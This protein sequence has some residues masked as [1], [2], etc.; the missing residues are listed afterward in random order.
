MEEA[1]F[2]KVERRGLIVYLYYNRDVKKLKKYGDILYHSRKH[3][4]V[5]IYVNQDQVEELE[6]KLKEESFV[7]E[8]K[9]TLLQDLDQNFVGS[10]WREK[11][12]EK[13]QD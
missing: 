13:S 10:L 7:R 3:R 8:L 2:E 1:G 6:K 4:Y 11:E 5:Q 12:V 9:R